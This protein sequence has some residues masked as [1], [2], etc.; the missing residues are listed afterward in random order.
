M[1]NVYRRFGLELPR[2]ATWQSAMPAFKTDLT[3]METEAKAETLASR[4]H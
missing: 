4:V 3:D 2:N 1:R